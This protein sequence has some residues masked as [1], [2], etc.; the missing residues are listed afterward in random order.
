M[1]EQEEDAEEK[2]KDQKLATQIAKRKTKKSAE[3]KIEA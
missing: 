3:N 2:I 1:K